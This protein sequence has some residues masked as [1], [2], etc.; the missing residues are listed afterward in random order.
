MGTISYEVSV[1]LL[2]THSL[3][4]QVTFEI[5]VTDFKRSR[6]VEKDVQR[7]LGGAMEVLKHRTDVT[8]SIT[9]APVYGQKLDQL[10]EFLASTEGGEV[11]TID[12]YGNAAAP[13]TLRRTDSGSDEDPFIRRGSEALD[14][15][16]TSITALAS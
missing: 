3:G 9:F 15:Y 10:R 2:P 11:F 7:S 8:F 12:L 4:D 5:D 1:V 14:V 13:L 6:T 16:Q